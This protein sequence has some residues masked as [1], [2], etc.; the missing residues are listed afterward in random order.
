MEYVEQPQLP[1][2]IREHNV[3]DNEITDI[4]VRDVSFSKMRSGEVKGQKVDFKD[5]KIKIVDAQDNVV[6]E[7]S[8]ANNIISAIVSTLSIGSDNAAGLMAIP[9]TDNKYI[10]GAANARF[11]EIYSTDVVLGSGQ[12]AIGGIG[13][14]SQVIL[15]GTII[16]NPAGEDQHSHTG[17]CTI[18]VNSYQIRTD[19]GNKTLLTN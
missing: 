1:T 14:G 13:N 19:G 17:S 6:L 10:I 2:L 18:A 5:C 4:K 12:K 9:D 3:Q 16:T 15:T 7:M 11:K 8:G